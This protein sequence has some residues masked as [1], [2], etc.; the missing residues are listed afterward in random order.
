MNQSAH[1][2]F[3]NLLAIL[4]SI[5]VVMAPHAPHVPKWTVAFCLIALLIRLYAGLERRP[6]PAKPLL[7]SFAAVAIGGVLFSFGSLF[8]RD[9]AITLLLAMTVLKLLEMRSQ[10]DITVT[11]VLCYFLAITNFFYTQTIF[12]ALYS[13]GAAWLITGTMVSLQHRARP[14]KFLQVMRMSGLLL[15]QAVPVM[16]VLFLLFPRIEGPLWGLPKIQ[17]SGRTGL[18]D[19]MSPGSLSRLSLSDEIAFRAEFETPPEDAK[20]LYWRGPVLWDYDGRNWAAGQRI[21][22]SSFRYDS[23]A[24][25]LKYSVTL[26]PHDQRWLYL[27]DL[28]S[29]LPQ[30]SILTRDYQVVSFSPVRQRLRYSAESTPVY[31]AGT[32]ALPAELQRALALPPDAAPRTRAMVRQWRGL[33][34]SG[35]EIAQR[36]LSIYR[37]Q[38]FIYTLEPPPLP[39]DPVDQFLFETRRGFCEHFASSFAVMMRAAGVPTRVVTG[40]LGGEINPVDGYLVVRQSEAHAWNEIWTPD[41]GWVRVDP[42][43]A[44]SPL[45]IERGLANAVPDTDPQPLF[46]R[47]QLKWLVELRYQWDA[48]TNAWNQWVLGYTLERQTRFLSTFGFSNV[49]WQDMIITLLIATGIILSAFALGMFMR[50]RSNKTDAVQRLWLHY[51]NVMAARGVVRKTSEGPK[52]FTQR[53]AKRFPGLRERVVRIGELYIDLRYGKADAPSEQSTPRM[54]ELRTHIRAL[55]LAASPAGKTS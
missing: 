23:F 19:R 37:E 36:V 46:R 10:R 52:D 3:P 16:L 29:R 49:G 38:P 45:R 35:M 32:E 13:I 22:L 11:V 2:S 30:K 17:N 47:T 55:Y 53:V 51:C 6:L 54:R 1:L 44:V 20:K 8:G 15:A 42:T 33:G 4:L 28:P 34:L 31:R 5:V 7:F 41:E 18:S 12:T 48:V 25:N 21:P 43:A 24:P 50:L 39:K 27:V 9:S 26:E 14:A 40:Y